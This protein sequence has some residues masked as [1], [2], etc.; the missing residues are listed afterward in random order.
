MKNFNYEI[1]VPDSDEAEFLDDSLLQ[2]I[3]KVKPF[4]FD[5]AF[6][7]VN[8][9]A[10]KDGEIV[11]GVL[12]YAVMWDILYIDTVWTRKDCRGNGIA[13]RLLAEAERRASEIGCKTAHLSTY[14]FQAPAFYEKLRYVKFGEIDYGEV[15]EIFYYKRIKE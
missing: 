4:S 8:V 11:G 2:E 1:C 10:K 14:D 12:A 15:K 5:K 9:C 13:S 6:V 3:Q 7:P